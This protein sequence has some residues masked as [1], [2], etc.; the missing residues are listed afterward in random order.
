MDEK[1]EGLG[2]YSLASSC[3]ELRER[4]KMMNGEENGFLLEGD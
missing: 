3:L 2:S 1:Y 4:M